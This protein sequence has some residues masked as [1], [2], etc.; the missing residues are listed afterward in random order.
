M[1]DVLFVQNT[2]I[3]GSGYLGELVNEDGFNVQS[4]HAKKEN[5][6]QKEFSLV[7]ILGAPESA[8]DDL[9]YLQKN[10]N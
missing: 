1:S 9:Q 8:N 5:I 3:E 7:V 6:P 2:S 4:V 10:K